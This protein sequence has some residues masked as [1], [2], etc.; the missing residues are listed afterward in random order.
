MVEED[1]TI[2]VEIIKRMLKFFTD[3]DDYNL[4]IENFIDAFAFI[5]EKDNLQEFV[6]F[7]LFSARVLNSD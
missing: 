3:F 6:N 5:K 1:I 7:T 4:M 2:K